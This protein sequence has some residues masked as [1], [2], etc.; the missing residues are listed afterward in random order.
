MLL[1]LSFLSEFYELPVMLFWARSGYRHQRFRSAALVC[2]CSNVTVPHLAKLSDHN[3]G[4]GSSCQASQMKKASMEFVT[5]VVTR[6]I[7]LAIRFP[8]QQAFAVS[9]R[10][11][12][13]AQSSG[14]A[15]P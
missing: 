7:P 15:T 11:V 5:G 14:V 2:K 13:S 10:L 3:P 9:A 8:R 6:N 12:Q 4:V 1:V